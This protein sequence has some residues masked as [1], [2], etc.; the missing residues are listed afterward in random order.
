MRGLPL[1]RLMTAFGDEPYRIDWHGRREAVLPFLQSTSWE[2]PTVEIEVDGRPVEAW[3]DTGGDALTLPHAFGVEPLASFT[4]SYAGG[5]AGE[6]AY[7]RVE[8]VRLGPVTVRAVP[9]MTAGLERPVIGT[10]FLSRFLPTL[11]YPAGRLVLRPRE[12][13]P[14]SGVEMPFALAATHLLIVRG[15]LADR[16]D[17]TFVVDSGL[18]DE[19]GAAFAAPAGHAGGG[20][21]RATRDATGA[22]QLGRRRDD[23][24]G[25]PLRHPAPR[26][27]RGSSS[28]TWSASTGSSRRSSRLRRASRSTG[29]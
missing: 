15:S 19:P 27:R 1:S 5:T 13:E 21:H 28:A 12:A 11:D 29:W 3:I 24:R 18:E 8:S 2:L 14:P 7:G 16:D 22:R 6:G 26:A 9:V 17:L 23:A 20:R 25:R 10:G 4:G